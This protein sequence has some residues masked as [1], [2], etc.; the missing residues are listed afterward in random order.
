MAVPTKLN[1]VGFR[2]RQLRMDRQWTQRELSEKVRSL[3][4]NIT[5]GMLAKMESTEIRV[6]DCDLV[7]LAKAFKI[8]MNEFFPIELTS[9]IR[10][11]IHSYRLRTSDFSLKKF[12][13]HSPPKSRKKHLR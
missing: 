8:P 5:R 2:V 7:F 11:K 13:R 4:W 6:T 12:K 1:L 3:G 10:T 9:K